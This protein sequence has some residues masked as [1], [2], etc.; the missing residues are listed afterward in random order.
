MTSGLVACP[1]AGVLAVALFVGSPVVEGREADAKERFVSALRASRVAYETAIDSADDAYQLKVGRLGAVSATLTE[2]GR[3]T[4]LEGPAAEARR[5]RD[6][7]LESTN[8]DYVRRLREVAGDYAPAATVSGA[9]EATIGVL[10]TELEVYRAVAVV[11]D[12]AMADAA[13]SF[14]S[15]T[16]VDAVRD[17]DADS[18]E[19]AARRAR[20]S[21][22]EAVRA[23]EVAVANKP[24]QTRPR[25]TGGENFGR[26]LEGLNSLAQGD[27]AAAE[28]AAR[29]AGQAREAALSDAEA[30]NRAARAEYELAVGAAREVRDAAYS[31]YRASAATAQKAR[32]DAD[33]AVASRDRTATDYEAARSASRTAFVEL[34]R[35]TRI[36]QWAELREVERALMAGALSAV[37]GLDAEALSRITERTARQAIES[38][39]AGGFDQPRRAALEHLEALGLELTNSTEVLTERGAALEAAKRENAALTREANSAFE[40]AQNSYSRALESIDDSLV[41]HLI[42]AGTGIKGMKKRHEIVRTASEE[43]MRAEAAARQA[44]TAGLTQALPGLVVSEPGY[45]VFYSYVGALDGHSQADSL[46]RYKAARALADRQYSSRVVASWTRDTA[47]LERQYR[48]ALADRDAA[49][50]A[51]E[52]APDA[53]RHALAPPSGSTGDVGPLS[54][55][56]R[57]R[58]RLL[59][60]E[61]REGLRALA[62]GVENTDSQSQ[63]RQPLLE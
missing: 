5:S 33:Q 45:P 60:A 52:E 7:L 10:R 22:E 11:A 63:A 13:S 53:F 3:R 16:A 51:L 47:S 31:A 20:A 50:D 46:E 42:R 27:R 14:D 12:Q 6:A 40:T 57:A 26:F 59:E 49:R 61:V 43:H 2:E 41:D 23:Y 35:V 39:L 25:K 62:A 55:K 17:G 58:Y 15:A 38:A 9:V 21:Y 48:D 54:T 28:R 19:R 56:A 36:H 18:L 1:G 4:L 8:A 29:E 37:A 44:R 32:S 30:S 34:L 24:Q